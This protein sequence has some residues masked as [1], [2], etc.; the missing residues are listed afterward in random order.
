MVY[1]FIL[2]QKQQFM[3]LKTI[4][5]LTDKNKNSQIHTDNKQINLDKGIKWL[6]A[7]W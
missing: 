2:Q 7:N 4:P 5:G 1:K 3:S 6:S